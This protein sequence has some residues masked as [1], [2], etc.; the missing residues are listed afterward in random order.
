MAST[1]ARGGHGRVSGGEAR[2]A[3]M[4]HA[5]ARSTRRVKAV[6]FLSDF[7]ELLLHNVFLQSPRAPRLRVTFF[8]ASRISRTDCGAHD[9]TASATVDAPAEV[10]SVRAAEHLTPGAQYASPQVWSVRR[11]RHGVRYRNVAIARY[12]PASHHL[13][14][15]VSDRT[16]EWWC[17]RQQQPRPEHQRLGNRGRVFEPGRRVPSRRALAA[18]RVQG[19]EDPGRAE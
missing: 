3:E 9:A 16:T 10:R 18:W 6:A 2:H 1:R 11:A 14:A 5:E 19:S 4:A 7:Q 12:K 13:H 15:Q 8:S 17:G